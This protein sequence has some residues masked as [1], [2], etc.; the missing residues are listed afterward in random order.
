MNIE[1]RSIKA[2]DRTG[3][4]DV[5]ARDTKTGE[6]VLVMNEPDGWDGSDAR[7]LEVQERFNAYV[8]FL[9]DGEMASE[10]PDLAGK[11]A[12]IELRCAHM[13]DPRAIELLGMIHDQLAFQ[14]M[15]MEVVVA[16]E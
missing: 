16:G 9:L 6:V 10:H 3:L 14:E 11:P 4:I 13:P 15:R 7:L 2:K 8:S 5:I 12:R 1:N